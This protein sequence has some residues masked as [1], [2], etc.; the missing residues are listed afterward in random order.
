[1][2]WMRI[3]ERKRKFSLGTNFDSI[4]RTDNECDRV[5]IVWHE[6]GIGCWTLL[7]IVKKMSRIAIRNSYSIVRIFFVFWLHCVCTS[8]FWINFEFSLH[9][10]RFKT[11]LERGNISNPKCSSL[12]WRINPRLLLS[13]E[14]LERKKKRQSLISLAIRAHFQLLTILVAL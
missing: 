12:D 2:I 14:D 8:E 13:T 11:L 10:W 1:M 9:D 3:L 7:L 4:E 5:F 6:D